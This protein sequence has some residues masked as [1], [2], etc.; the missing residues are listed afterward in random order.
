MTRRFLY[1]PLIILIFFGSCTSK[2]TSVTY[3]S[4]R[5]VWPDT[6]PI[7][8]VG[9]WDGDPLFRNRR[10]GNPVWYNEEYGREYSEDAIIKL[11]QMGVTMVITDLFKGFG[12][13]AEKEQQEYTKRIITLCHRHGLKAGVYVGSTICFETFLLEEPDAQKWF[14]PD[15]MGKPVLWD[16][17][18]PFRK[19]VY[20]MHPGYMNYIKKVL[21]TA[22]VDLKVDLIHFDNTSERAE[23]PVFFHPQAK[24]DFRAFLRQNYTPQELKE[25]LGFSDVSYVEPPLFSEPISRINEPLFQLWTDFRCHQLAEFYSEMERYIHQLNP[26]TVVENNPCYGLSGVNTEWSCGMYYPDLL[27]HTSF[28]WSEE[29]DEAGYSAE[30]ILI[31]KIRSYKMASHLKNKIF[32]YTGENPLQIAEAMAYNRQCLGMIGGVLAGYELEEKREDIGFDNPYALG[33]YTEDPEIRQKKA[34]YVRYFHD[35]FRYYRDID[36][37]ADVAVLHSY[38]TLA[39]NNDRPYQ[40]LYL[41]EQALIQG[42][43]PFDI[44]YDN[45]LKDLSGYKVLVLADVECLSDEKLE[46]I[47]NFV[48]KG[49]GL[50]ATEHTSLYTEFRNRKREFG[51]KDLFQTSA[52]RYLGNRY[53]ESI[54]NISVLKSH[55]G[56]GRV[57]YIPEVIPAIPKPATEEMRSLYWKLPLNWKE[58]IESVKWA[59]G[60]EL[61]IETDAP[62][63]VA[64]ELTGKNDQSSIML[65][66]LNYNVDRDTVI[67]NIRVGLNISGGREINEVEMLSPDLKTPR[68]LNFQFTQNLVSF[69]VPELRVYDLMVIRLKKAGEK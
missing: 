4:S 43:V 21:R 25:R 16:S 28:I 29:G 19:R 51:L 66:L 55:S 32:T 52:P 56:D 17:R 26:M 38:S 39:F 3:Q 10:G 18:Q 9:N 15:F 61:I 1:V 65:H 42:K 14:V 68:K 30:G 11:R 60:G 54:L 63:T 33:A 53:P 59:G 40:S 35:N 12:L 37:I 47:R 45:D 8:M 46:L 64:I 20:F 2:N 27:S 69:T 57:V 6:M 22:I 36:N 24:K 50:A 31:S 34:D 23:G 13:E 44:I 67:K 58:L 5:P 48:K 41:F 62:E 49:G 7:I